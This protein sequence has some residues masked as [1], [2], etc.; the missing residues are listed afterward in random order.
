M[1]GAGA[2]PTTGGQAGFQFNPDGS[3]FCTGIGGNSTYNV[4]GYTGPDSWIATRWFPDN[5]SYNFEP[6]NLLVLPLERWNIY[7]HFDL[8]VND[9]FRPYAT[10]MFTNYNATQELAPTPAAGSTGFTV[11]VTN[12]FLPDTMRAMLASRPNPDANF[13]FSKRFK[14]LGGR[15]GANDHDVWQATLGATGLIA[16]SWN[17][18]AYGSF[19]RS[20]AARA[21]GRRTSSAAGR[22]IAGRGRRRRFDLRGWP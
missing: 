17:Y 20:S 10:A 3:L 4:V 5:F 13:S 11:P 14:D 2:C 16:G 22:R 21:P 7:S 12:P 9:H 8:E 15:T 19:G 1:F 6:D 18:D